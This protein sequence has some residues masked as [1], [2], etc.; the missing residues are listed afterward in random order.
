MFL[1]KAPLKHLPNVMLFVSSQDLILRPLTF[2][3]DI[4]KSRFTQL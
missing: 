2:I 4:H 3:L 1:A